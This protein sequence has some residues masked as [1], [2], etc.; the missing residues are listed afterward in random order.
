MTIENDISSKPCQCGD[1]MES[2]IK[3][4][5]ESNTRIGWYCPKCRKFDKAIGRERKV[6]GLLSEGKR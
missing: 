3:C 5:S 6:E 4:T 2:V 1:A